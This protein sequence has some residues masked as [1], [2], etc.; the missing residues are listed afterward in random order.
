MEDQHPSIRIACEGTLTVELDELAE[1]QHYKDLTEQAYI[2][3]KT[4]ILEL[5]FSFPIFIWEDNGIKWIIDAHQRKRILTKMRDEEGFTIPPL[6]AVR[7]QAANKTEAKKKILAQESQYGDITQEGLYEFINEEDSLL[8]AV[9]LS[10][11]VDIN[12]FAL[13]YGTPEENVTEDEAPEISPE[14]AKSELGKVYQLG[15][16]RLYC[17]DSTIKE[18]VVKLLGE[19]IQQNTMQDMSTDVSTKHALS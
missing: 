5:G 13:E 3:G 6:P 14:P 16:H 11:F 2:K 7:I 17:G 18:N 10:G 8:D 19:A 15:R 1:M 9:D 12:E 4:S